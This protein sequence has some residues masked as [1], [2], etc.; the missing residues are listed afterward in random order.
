MVH[1]LTVG[2]EG[3]CAPF[4]IS[5]SRKNARFQ[6]AKP[7]APRDSNPRRANPRAAFGAQTVKTRRGAANGNE[8][9]DPEELGIKRDFRDHTIQ[10]CRQR[11]PGNASHV[12]ASGWDHSAKIA[13]LTAQFRIRLVQPCP[14]AANARKTATV[15]VS[16]WVW[17]ASS[18]NS[19]A[20]ARRSSSKTSSWETIPARRLSSV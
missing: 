16:S 1:R 2:R 4:S 14:V 6:G 12:T 17:M 15:S 7:S 10:I 20:S 5:I 9:R 8:P 18:L 11:I 19:A 13:I 3:F